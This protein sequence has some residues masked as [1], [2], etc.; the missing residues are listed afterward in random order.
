MTSNPVFLDPRGNPIQSAVCGSQY[1]MT[2]PGFEGQQLFISQMKNG[3]QQFAGQMSIPMSLYTSV[4]NQDEGSYQTTAYTLDGSLLGSTTFT[5]QPGAASATPAAPG[6]A[7]SAAP[8]PGTTSAVSPLPVV[9]APT[10]TTTVGSFFSSLT[11]TEWILL[12]AVGL[13]IINQTGK[14]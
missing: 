13:I 2:V 9:P 3:A 4:C 12:A 6:G 11:T 8:P 10:T 14:R 1:S 7:P 5:V